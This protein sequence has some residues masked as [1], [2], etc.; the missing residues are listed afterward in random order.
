ME[1]EREKKYVLIKAGKELPIVKIVSWMKEREEMA[2]VGEDGSCMK[3][4]R[5]IGREI[6]SRREKLQKEI[7]DNLSL[8][9]SG[10]K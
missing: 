5:L 4:M 6:Y 8:L 2:M 3:D 10:G 9:V 7:S 1:D